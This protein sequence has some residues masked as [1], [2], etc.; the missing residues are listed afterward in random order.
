MKKQQ[1]FTDY[2]TRLTKGTDA[3]LYRLIPERVE[4]VNNE[5]EVINLLRQCREEG[6]SVTFK[7]GGTSLSGQ[8]ITNSVLMEIGPDFGPSEVLADGS[9]V[10]LSCHITGE[11]ANKL[12]KSYGRKL[13]PSPASIKSAKIGGIIANNASGSSYGIT[14]NSYHTLSSMRVIM[15]DG[16]LLD[17]SSKESREAFAVTHANLLTELSRLRSHVLSN[18]AIAQ[19][20]RHKYELKNTCGYG[21]N[22][23]ID[24]ENPID[25][26]SHLMVGSEGTLGFISRVVLETVPD[27]K[28]KASA[29]VYFPGIEEACKAIIPLRQCVVSAAELMDRKALRAVEDEPG[30]PE[31]LRS[32]PE[33][34]VALLID[35]SADTIDELKSQLKEIE[36]KLSVI[37]TLFPVSFTTDPK[38]YAAYWKVRSGLFTSAAA[39]RPK[40]TASIIEDI[41]FRGE[42]L[43]EALTTVTKLLSAYNYSDAVMWG[44]LLDGNVHFTVFPDINREDGIR[45][46][47]DFMYALTDLVLR[48]DGSLKA[49]HGT[50]RNV[51]PFVRQE[52]GDDIYAVMKE[53]KRI[54]D[55]GNLLN[56]G[57]IINDDP[58]VLISNLKQMPLANELIDQC[59]ECGFCE[60]QCPSKNLTLTPRQRIVVYRTLAGMSA[61]GETDTP[62]YKELRQGFAYQGNATCATDGLCGVTCPVGINTG[63]LIKELRWEENSPISN[64]IAGFIANHLKGVT[65]SLRPLLSLPHILSN[66]IGYRAME[67][68]TKG[69]FKLSGHRFPLWTRYTPRGARK[70]SF[71]SEKAGIEHLEMVYFPSC[72]TRTMGRS[73]DYT[74]KVSVTEKTIELLHKA[75]FAIRYPWNIHSLCCGM[76]FSSKG[77]RQQAAQ[78]ED[79]L[80][81]VLLEASDNGRLP[82]L[83]DMSPCLLHMRESLD[84]RLKL[85]E[86]VA[87]IHEFMIG[88]LSF[89]QLPI[90]VAIH[91]T[92]STTKMGMQEKLYGLASMCAR[93]VV[94]PDG[95][96]C[97]GWAGDRGFFYPELNASALRFLPSET[98]G[99]TEGYSN[100]R[101]CEI[102]LSMNS[103]ISYK[104]I[105]FLV[106]KATR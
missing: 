19:K 39:K 91:P 83:C 24:F 44:H 9:L 105:V 90:T 84:K 17:T 38:I 97:C 106:D 28:L 87:F 22:A 48:Y 94:W 85:Y 1:S 62:L 61:R 23:L 92:C 69:L 41:A 103:S 77:F 104:S 47:R 30:M 101:T 3:G 99:A 50:G 68:V 15:G 12:L 76:A 57:V 34:T 72:I 102:G 70:L 98:K 42:I 79:E 21:V 73:A 5:E 7:A 46:Y 96:T 67:S 26:L 36:Q 64:K 93:E 51:A 37:D 29:L 25:I 95:V 6:K 45:N 54:I 11:R 43:G 52:W 2:L 71:Q 33:D 88:R 66:V 35:T 31:V 18:P 63:T 75:N 65:A 14:Y 10:S 80:N 20:I 40:G 56:P 55:P 16:T 4:I 53:I 86:P 49:E 32:L 81:E 100:S 27:P 78:K 58:A 59:I 13:G 60:I 8:T 82:I 89:K 74:E